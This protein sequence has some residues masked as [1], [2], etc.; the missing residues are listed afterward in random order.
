[1]VEAMAVRRNGTRAI[2]VINKASGLATINH[3]A[4]HLEGSAMNILLR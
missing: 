4:A 3:L 2:M 1:M